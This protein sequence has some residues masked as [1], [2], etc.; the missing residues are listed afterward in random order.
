MSSIN[1]AFKNIK[2]SF[3]DFTIYFLTL[4]FAIALIYSFNAILTFTQNLPKMFI[5]EGVD[6]GLKSIIL[7]LSLFM[8]LLFGLMVIFANRFLIKRRFKELGIY[9]VLGMKRKKIAFI[10]GAETFF[11]GLLSLIAGITLGVFLS[12]FIGIIIYKTLGADPSQMNFTF[13]KDGAVISIIAF[14]VTFLL[15]GL[16]NILMVSRLKVLNLVNYEKVNEKVR[17]PSILTAI[18]GIL[19]IVILIYAYNLII[20]SKFNPNNGNDFYYAIILG[21]IGNFLFFNVFTSTV[22]TLVKKIKGLYYKQ[23]SPFTIRQIDSKV[24]TNSNYMAVI[25]LT[26]MISFGAITAGYSIIDTIKD[27]IKG[28]HYKEFSLQIFNHGEKE[29]FK[30]EI[31]N[32]IKEDLKDKIKNVVI[33]SYYNDYNYNLDNANSKELFDFYKLKRGI[34]MSIIDV[35]DV[36]PESYINN[37][38]QSSDKTPLKAGETILISRDKEYIESLKKKLETKELKII[39][40]E[41]EHIIKDIVYSEIMDDIYGGSITIGALINNKDGMAKMYSSTNIFG[42]LTVNNEKTKREIYDYIENIIDSKLFKG[43]Y[44]SNNSEYV[45]E[46]EIR[47][48]TLYM[49]FITGFIGLAFLI[50]AL[51]IMSLRELGDVQ[52]SIGK[53]NVLRRLGASP[54]MINKSILTQISMTFIIPLIVGLIH[55]LVG[56]YAAIPVINLFGNFNFTKSV[57]V[58]ILTI[59]VIY[60]I[61][62]LLT[63]SGSNRIIKEKSGYLKK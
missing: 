62:M 42:E 47:T 16:L 12:Q 36:K 22:L 8:S 58:P 25:A 29:D 32:K 4:T 19:S 9:M 48:I 60:L 37:V 17:K 35:K 30:E 13:S 53:Y 33:Y 26:M 34:R 51:A 15:V 2:R 41:K 3:K 18:L 50:S 1:I 7:V 39:L 10:L 40:F 55:A 14:S 61:Y 45:L 54:R 44:I 43:T 46:L 11:M 6:T 5:L 57:P 20:K 38:L 21:L 56:I 24:R 28:L 49:M 52:D 27:T 23:I 63:Y 59:V 31:A